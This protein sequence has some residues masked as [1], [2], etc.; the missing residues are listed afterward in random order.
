MKAKINI[1]ENAICEYYKNNQCGV[2]EV[3]KVFK[4]GKKR[5]REIL[6]ANG[7]ERRKRGGQVLNEQYIVPDYHIEKFRPIEGEHYVAIDKESGFQ[8]KD[9]MN[10]AGVLTSHIKEAYKVEI[11]TLYDRRLYYMR[12][13]NYWWEQWFDI[14][15]VK[16]AEVK[17]CPYCNWTT[18]DL[19]NRSGMFETHLLKAHGITKLEYLKVHPED[20]D[21]FATVNSTVQ[22]Q[23]EEDSNEYIVCAICGQKM[24]YM[25]RS[26]LEKHGL[27]RNEYRMKFGLKRL[28]CDAY[29]N[30]MS[31]LTTER[32][33]TML[34]H[35][36]SACEN[37]IRD[38]IEDLGIET[39]VDREILKG[40]EIDIYIPSM[41]IGFEYH[42]LKWHSE[43]HQPDRMYHLD[44]TTRCLENGVILYQIFEDE[45][46]NRKEVV[47]NKIQH[48]LNASVGPRV[49]G[50]KC[51]IKEITKEDAHKF[52]EVNHVQGKV[53]ATLYLGAF[54]RNKLVGVMT[55]LYSGSEWQLTRCAT[56]IT[57]RCSGVCGKMFKYFVK[58]YHYTSIISFADRRWTPSEDNN[59]YTQLGF[60]LIDVLPPDYSYYNED[61]LRCIREHKFK[62]RKAKLIRKYGFALD[63][64]EKEMMQELGYERIWNCGLFKYIYRNPDIKTI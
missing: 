32:N 7:V 49:Y 25:S 10:S 30:K 53:N 50:R 57:K 61:D 13:G 29:Y 40:K 16:D 4:I 17:K 12:T 24:R 27:T 8:T 1:N 20:K 22:L 59:L 21:Y 5:V 63:M 52:L 9:Y 15:S 60:K 33:K 38:Y 19:E 46:K 39:T 44:K 6:A 41:K 3:A 45:Y 55:F 26:H 47:L 2:D 31:V 18:I 48:I 54:Y 36:H 43:K 62:F 64:S 37:E 14:I 23:M 34:N 58:N 51:I 11:P 28:T 35:Y 42:G 56:D